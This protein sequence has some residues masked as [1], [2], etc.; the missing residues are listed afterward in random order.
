MDNNILMGCMLN[1]EQAK[2]FK[3]KVKGRTV[4]A[5]YFFCQMVI[6]DKIELEFDGRN[7][8]LFTTSAWEV[9]DK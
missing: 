6:E 9:S 2:K 5:I 7:C 4:D 1:D 8:T 3:E